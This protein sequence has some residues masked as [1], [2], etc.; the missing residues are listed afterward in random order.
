ML[1]DSD[2][3]LRA[4]WAR[5]ELTRRFIDHPAISLIEIGLEPAIEAGQAGDRLEIRI[6]VRQPD[7]W[8]APALP[9]EMNGIPIRVI[10][11]DYRLE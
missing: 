3:W 2:E 10:A 11:G 4:H 9:D 5:E 1:R 6:H 7:A 8:R